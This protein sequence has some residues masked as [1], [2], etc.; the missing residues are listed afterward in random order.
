M[1]GRHYF[2]ARGAVSW[3]SPT[4]TVRTRNPY[5][6]YGY[7]FITQSDESP[8][9][10]A[11]S[12]S[13]V[14]SCHPMPED[15]HSLYEVDGF[16]WMQGWKESLPSYSRQGRRHPEGGHHQSYRMQP[17]ESWW[18][19][20]PP[21]PTPRCWIEKNQKELGTMS[22]QL[23]VNTSSS[24]YTVGVERSATYP[25][26]DFGE[27]DTIEIQPLSGGPI[28]LDYVAVTW[29]QPAP[30]AGFGSQIPAAEYVYGITPQDHHA[31][32]AADMVIII[33]TSQK[34]LE[35]AQRLR[36][37]P[38]NPRRAAREHRARR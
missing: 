21:V 22:L 25:L 33:P 20:L 15:Y 19:L 36:E 31:D 16:S 34:L 8:S 29:E 38:R 28:H 17:G 3:S 30:F 6:D 18:W 14:S 13:F 26:R 37:F 9:L 24:A 7:Y 23:P 10:W 35:Q 32:G 4:A 1:D 11:D 5:S 12:A 27:K 2:Y